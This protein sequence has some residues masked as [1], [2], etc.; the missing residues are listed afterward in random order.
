[1]TWRLAFAADGARYQLDASLGLPGATGGRMTLAADLTGMP[2]RAGGWAADLYLR[3]DRMPLQRL[4]RDRLPRGY[5]FASGLAELATWS[6]WQGGRLAGVIGR[7]GVSDVL[8]TGPDGRRL[9]LPRAGGR[10]RWRRLATG[11]QLEAA[12][13][14]LQRAGHRWP[15][16]AL[17]LASE[18]DSQGHARVRLG[19]DFLRIEDL[20]AMVDMFPTPDNRFTQALAVTA[21]AG[22]VH[23]LRVQYADDGGRPRWSAQG[24]VAGLK[25]GVWKKAPGVA[26]LD[27]RFWADQ[28]GGRA[29]LDSSDLTVELPR[30]FRAP[31]SLERLSGRVDWQRGANGGWR[32]DAPDV[33]ASNRDI[34][35][36]SRL[37]LD[38]PAA[39]EASPVLDMQT[40]FYDGDAA[41]AG[42]YY[43]TGIMG[44]KLVRWL[45]RAVVSGRV[46]SGG[47]IVH[48]PLR[49]FP[50]HRTYGG[51]FEVL[52]GV[53][54]LVLDYHEDWPRLKG[55]SA[56][57][58]FLDNSF[59]AQIHRGDI[60]GSRV[61][62][63]RAQIDSLHPVSAAH[64]QGRVSSSVGDDLRLLRETPLAGTFKRLTAGVRGNGPTGLSIDLHLPLAHREMGHLKLDGTLGFEKASLSLPGWKLDLDQIQGDV[65]FSE[66]AV[67]AQGVTAKA[68]GSAVVID[69]ETPG[70]EPPR[71]RIKARGPLSAQVL[72]GR[73]PVARVAEPQGRSDWLLTLDIPRREAGQ[74]PRLT[75]AS[76]LKGI[77]LGLPAPLGKPAET[78]RPLRVETELVDA[79]PFSLR[80]SYAALL[81]GRFLLQHD[82]DGVRLLRGGV[83]LGGAQAVLPTRDDGLEV[84]GSI[85]ALDIVPWLAYA[86]RQ[87]GQQAGQGP[88]GLATIDLG[89]GRL[90][91][92]DAFSLEKVVLKLQ[93]DGDALAGQ[94][95]SD[96]LNGFVSIPRSF[97]SAPILARLDSLDLDF[98]VAAEIGKE[99][100]PRSDLDPR[101]F[102]GL[103]VKVQHLNV[104]Q[105]DLGELAVFATRVPDG[106]SFDRLELSTEHLKAHAEG[107]WVR[108]P[109][110]GARS[111]VSFDL[112]TGNPA[113]VLAAL[114][115]SPNV[116]AKRASLAGS[117][118]WPG[119]PADLERSTVAGRVEMGVGEGQFLELEPGVGRVFGLL[120]LGTLQ[121]RLSLDFTDL[122]G[123]G[124]SFDK[125]AGS[126]VLKD[127]DA[128]TDDLIIQGPSARLALIGRIGL[129]GEDF[130]QVVTVT[131][132]LSSTI[133]VAGAIAGGPAVGAALLLAQRLMGDRVDRIGRY[134]FSVTGPWGEPKVERLARAE[135]VVAPTGPAPEPPGQT[136]ENK[137]AAGSSQA[138]AQGASEPGG[139]GP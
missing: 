46:V 134:R 64:I 12:D 42:H 83:G 38:L 110:A 102:P 10:F 96:R 88:P 127:G 77:A 124:L 128:F 72:L 18:L 20:L 35:T 2:D 107:R 36:R 45:D 66:S 62:Q 135:A 17:A 80:L 138:P 81:D 75:L 59:D 84:H 6:H 120:S 1:M 31:L 23:D 61:L 24:S 104:N 87:L 132:E 58:H 139:K 47:V 4:L 11:W 5:G 52:F 15:R 26:G 60:L 7:V 111:S 3:G 118:E 55:V 65:H 99:A 93:P 122:V 129:V 21:P 53:T 44:P 89:V 29:E 69:V 137:P 63:A 125:I 32:I 27:G 43:P 25:A 97:A 73:V 92:G 14:E 70:D 126:F 85:P 95:A 54:D 106:L 115:F 67:Q 51:R 130:D 116:K 133:P 117:L 114:G 113:K 50:F 90:A 16:S 112:E 49:E 101:A 79:G 68:L 22:D 136:A 91:Y 76:D 39:P 121:R 119:S 100:R 37:R 30:L 9:D 74:T 13:I 82:A 28:D 123:K 109:D 40:N 8:L 57:V 34:R 105:T 33:A 19:A 108:N 94:V 41:E 56:D 103:D 78:A 98:A 48:G 86:K 71:T 131:P